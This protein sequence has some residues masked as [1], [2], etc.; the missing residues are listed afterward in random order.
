[1]KSFD[2]ADQNC[3]LR[4]LSLDDF[5]VLK[6]KLEYIALSAGCTITQPYEPN[7]YVFFPL[8]GFVSVSRPLACN[9]VEVG[10]IGHEGLVGLNVVLGSDSCPDNISVQMPGVFLR[11]P[12]S[13]L[14]AAMEARLT[15][16]R[17]LLRYAQTFLVQLASSALATAVLK[18]ESR[19]ARWLLMCHDRAASD[20]IVVTHDF[21]ALLLSVSRPGL[22]V[23]THVLE[24]AGLIRA[25]RGKIEIRN[26]LGLEQLVQGTYGPAEAE[27]ERLIGFKI[28]RSPAN[29]AGRIRSGRAD[30]RREQLGEAPTRDQP[31]AGARGNAQDGG[32]RYGGPLA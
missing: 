22:T 30:V 11:V 32:R 4:A 20:Q 16:S 24:G 2:E 12:A 21:L 18:T 29:P 10:M 19:V 25:L 3:L 23:A 31:F 17:L 26:R 14:L 5:A 28:R 27:Y 1:M 9:R 13:D 6:P 7:E 15:I 8:S